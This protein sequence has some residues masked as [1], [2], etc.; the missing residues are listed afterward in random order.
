MSMPA[1]LTAGGYEAKTS[2]DDRFGM[3]EA[4]LA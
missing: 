3:G 1:F 4:P 2:V